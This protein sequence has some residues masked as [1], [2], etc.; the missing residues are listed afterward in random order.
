MET[1]GFLGAFQ[2][3]KMEAE[4]FFSHRLWTLQVVLGG[5]LLV[6]CQRQPRFKKDQKHGYVVVLA[7]CHMTE[8]ANDQ[9]V[10]PAYSA[11][12]GSGTT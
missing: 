5:I 12:G 8:T 10:F 4:P 6:V 3:E 9:I 11:L 7:E 2:A 1:H